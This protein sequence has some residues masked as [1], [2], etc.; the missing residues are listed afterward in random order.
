[1][2]LLQKFLALAQRQCHEYHQMVM[3]FAS[4]NHQMTSHNIQ[5]CCIYEFDCLNLINQTTLVFFQRMDKIKCHVVNKY[6]IIKHLTTVEIQ[7]ERDSIFRKSLTSYSAV[8]IHAVELKQ[9]FGDD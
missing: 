2:R 1:M 8:K 7:K 5:N 6:F 3:I 4:L 9:C